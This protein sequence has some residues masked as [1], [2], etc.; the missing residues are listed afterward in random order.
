MGVDMFKT[1]V[2]N[3]LYILRAAG[4]GFLL[5][6]NAD[7]EVYTLKPNYGEYQ[8]WHAFDLG[9]NRWLLKNRRTAYALDSNKGSVYTHEENRGG[10]Q[11]WNVRLDT[12][13]AHI[14]LQNSLTKQWLS[15]DGGRVF[16]ADAIS[17]DQQRWLLELANLTIYTD[18]GSIEFEYPSDP[19]IEPTEVD[20]ED[21]NNLSSLPLED[22]YTHTHTESHDFEISFT[23]TLGFEASVEFTEGVP[24]IASAKESLTMSAQ[25]SSTQS[26]S[27]S[28]SYEYEF[29][30]NVAVPPFSRA[31]ATSVFYEASNLVL[32]FK[33]TLDLAGTYTGRDLKAEEL[34]KLM[35]AV[36]QNNSTFLGQNGG[37]GV[38][39]AVTG[40][41]KTGYGVKKETTLVSVPV[42][43][44]LTPERAR[45][46][47]IVVLAGLGANGATSVTFGQYE[48]EIRDRDKCANTVSV[49]VPQMAGGATEVVLWNNGLSSD[50][51]AF[52]VDA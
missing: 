2:D 3:Y 34:E 28:D 8:N 27:K 14:N 10:Y 42:Y 12:D 21:Y 4:T 13:G 5:D 26:S 51:A 7:K 47:D 25:I 23:E 6:S 11:I 46:G 30:L 50:P 43:V 16:A 49:A 39:M 9:D 17:G 24:E 20:A 19:D 33:M 22:T 40:T 29:S 41:L 37:Y 45:A 35:A 15:H 44:Q 18:I 1:F 32:P 38:R 31:R 48:A 36:A 52:V